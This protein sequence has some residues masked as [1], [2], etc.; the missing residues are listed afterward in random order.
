[1][2]DFSNPAHTEVGVVETAIFV[3]NKIAN[4][5]R[6]LPRAHLHDP[7]QGNAIE[8]PGTSFEI[9]VHVLLRAR[10]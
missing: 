10:Q 1:M 7:E 3:S 2:V 5:D 6:Q 9:D 4:L 8:S